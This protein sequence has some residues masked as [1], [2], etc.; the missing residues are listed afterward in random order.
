MSNELA[1][2]TELSRGLFSGA[3]TLLGW[4]CKNHDPSGFKVAN[5]D[6][7]VRQLRNLK[8]EGTLLFGSTQQLDQANQHLLD[9]YE[10]VK[11]AGTPESNKAALDHF[12]NAWQQAWSNRVSEKSRELFCCI[13]AASEK[14]LR[15]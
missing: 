1:G 12:I 4:F 7:I 2:L 14:V 15:A 8:K 6:R 10:M 5:C 9:F 3:F 13:A 11:P